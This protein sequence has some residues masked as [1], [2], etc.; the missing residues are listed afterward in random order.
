M[1]VTI[2]DRQ[3]RIAFGY[4]PPPPI[5]QKQSSWIQHPGVG[6]TECRLECLGDDTHPSH[7][8]VRQHAYCSPSDNFNRSIG[9]RI[10]LTRALRAA[11]SREGRKEAWAAIW[12][13]RRKVTQKPWS[14]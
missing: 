4:L 3:Y 13:A 8:Q 2:Q 7:V 9:R 1:I 11:F 5:K 6:I 12:E 10:A 14:L